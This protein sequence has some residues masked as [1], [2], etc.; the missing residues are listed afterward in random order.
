MTNKQLLND[1]IALVLMAVA[2]ILCLFIQG[3]TMT[4]YEQGYQDAMQGLECAP[5]FG[6]TAR[7]EYKD[8]YLTAV[9]DQLNGVTE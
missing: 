4:A 9:F 1:A 8:G 5:P 7:T 3:F 6:D 2:F